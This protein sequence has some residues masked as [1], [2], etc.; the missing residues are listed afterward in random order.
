MPEKG[1][2]LLIAATSVLVAEG[3][4]VRLRVVGEGPLRDDLAAQIR[5]LG[6]EDAV[7]LDGSVS[8]DQLGAAIDGCH[9][10]VVPSRREGLGLVAVD[11]IDRRRP[12]VAAAVGGLPET[13]LGGATGAPGT[14]DGASDVP[15]EGRDAPYGILV[16]PGDVAALARALRRLP[17]PLLPEGPARFHELHDPAR[18]V[19]EHLRAYEGVVG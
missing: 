5:G 2:D 9:A 16:R 12:V 10:L 19:Q 11:A 7:S 13:L 15:A 1:F 17:L 14:G 4:P 6:L 8:R 18:V 3:R